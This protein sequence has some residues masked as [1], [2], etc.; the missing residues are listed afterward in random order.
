MRKLSVPVIVTFFIYCL[1]LSSCGPVEPSTY[2]ERLYRISTVQSYPDKNEAEIVP[3]KIG[4]FQ[5]SIYLKNFNKPS[6]LSLFGVNSGDRVLAT[7]EL[8]A[9]G[10][11]DNNTVELI[12]LEKIHVQNLETSRPADSLNYYYRFAI[13]IL[14][15]TSY[16]TIWNTGHIINVCPIFFIPDNAPNPRFYFY[17]ERVVSDTLVIRLYSFIPEDD[18]SLNPDYT[19]TILNCD[20][21]SI[22]APV[23]N[24]DEQMRRDL[25]LASLRM[26][27]RDNI[28]VKIVTPDTLR[29]KNSK[30]IANPRYIQPVPGLPQTVQIPFDF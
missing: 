1:L 20:I 3:D 8:S 21:S 15:N 25:M 27:E 11:M 24:P 2:T 29:A 14:G 7:M 16:P 30:N 19:Q 18:I 28:Y 22:A 17:P 26:Q 12:D 9:T 5:E 13:S 23:S 4:E 6:H 10:T